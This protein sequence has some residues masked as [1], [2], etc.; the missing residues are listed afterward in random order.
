MSKLAQLEVECGRDL[1][2]DGL[3]GWMN[4]K[5]MTEVRKRYFAGEHARG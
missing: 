1:G 3:G 2:L 5:V 4:C